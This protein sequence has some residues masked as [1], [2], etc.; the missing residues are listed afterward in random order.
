MLDRR[1]FFGRASAAALFPSLHDS[2]SSST[3]QETLVPNDTIYKVFDILL[4]DFVDTEELSE[5]TLFV[6]GQIDNEEECMEEIFLLPYGVNI[7]SSNSQIVIDR[8]NIGVITD[9][10]SIDG[11]VTRTLNKMLETLEDGQCVDIS[12]C[13]S[14]KVYQS[15]FGKAVTRETVQDFQHRYENEI[16]TPYLHTF[17]QI[18]PDLPL[19]LQNGINSYSMEYNDCMRRI[20]RKFDVPHDTL[21]SWYCEEEPIINKIGNSFV[22]AKKELQYYLLNQDNEFHELLQSYFQD[23]WGLKIDNKNIVHLTID[24]NDLDNTTQHTFV[25]SLNTL[26]QTDAVQIH[27]LSYGEIAFRIVPTAIRVPAARHLTYAL[28]PI[29]RFDF[30]PQSCAL[31]NTLRFLKDISKHYSKYPAAYSDATSTLLNLLSHTSRDST[32]T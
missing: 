10:L 26:L 22:H 29:E 28:G 4:R 5:N 9:I 27:N 23:R 19:L 1:S 20:C 13:D 18:D 25:E 6:S 17:S 24:L 3:P 12:T 8:S 31:R 2:V 7:L 32:D 14:L 15:I 16:R 11:R 21:L 30:T